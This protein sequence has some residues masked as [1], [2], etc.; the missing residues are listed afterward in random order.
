MQIVEKDAGQAP[1]EKAD[2][3]CQFRATEAGFADLERN[4]AGVGLLA[5]TAVT[6]QRLMF[7]CF[8]GLGYHLDLLKYGCGVLGVHLNRAATVRAD[9]VGILHQPVRFVSRQRLPQTPLM[10][11]L[12]SAFVFAG[13]TSSF[14]R[15]DDVRRR[16]LGT[17]GRILS[18]AGQL[19]FAFLDPQRLLRN[20]WTQLLRKL[21]QPLT[22]RALVGMRR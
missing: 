13:R 5:C 16:R 6:P 9:V 3:A 19:S 4:W 7:S 11:L 18:G 1:L 8:D 2:D 22:V 10:P 14:A 12:A 21:L 15:L 17:V 20:L